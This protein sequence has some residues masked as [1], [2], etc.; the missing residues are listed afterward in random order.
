MDSCEA[1][2][3]FLNHFETIVMDLMW[4]DAAIVAA[5]HTKLTPKI[6]ETIHLLCPH[7]WPK[8]FAD[9]KKVAQDAKNYIRIRKRT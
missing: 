5:L 7:S 1:I 8:T 6:S 9:L 2:Q 3:T 4:N